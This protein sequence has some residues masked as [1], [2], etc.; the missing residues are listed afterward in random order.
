[1]FVVQHIC[2]MPSSGHIP[3]DICRV[4]KTAHVVSGMGFI[5]MATNISTASFEVLQFVVGATFFCKRLICLPSLA[6][7]LW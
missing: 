5:G 3:R 1:M 4:T 7:K 2:V 6:T